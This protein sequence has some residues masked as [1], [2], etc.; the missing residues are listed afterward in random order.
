MHELLKDNPELEEFLIKHGQ[1]NAKWV[2]GL[3]LY[4][5]RIDLQID[6]G[7]SPKKVVR[8]VVQDFLSNL[9]RVYGSIE[10]EIEKLLPHFVASRLERYAEG[11]MGD[12]LE[13][14]M[15]YVNDRINSR[16]INSSK[17]GKKPTRGFDS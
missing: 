16:S 12:G 15:Q 14:T 8:G 3:S 2:Q 9:E 11:I 5:D 10:S 17:H 4:L 6:Q 13:S 7:I 1:E